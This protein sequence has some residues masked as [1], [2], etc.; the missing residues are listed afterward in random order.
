MS[1]EIKPTKMERAKSWN[2]AVEEGRS[3]YYTLLQTMLVMS[4]PLDHA[5]VHVSLCFA[6]AYRFQLAGYRDENEY[7]TVNKGSEV[8][9]VR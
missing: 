3:N 7:L 9:E 1:A 6:A 8:N 5:L 2:D 4:A